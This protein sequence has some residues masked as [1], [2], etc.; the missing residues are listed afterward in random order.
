MAHHAILSAIRS[1]ERTEAYP[2]GS[3]K[4][5][6]FPRELDAAIEAG[7]SEVSKS[8]GEAAN[9]SKRLLDLLP[10]RHAADE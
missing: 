9:E 3:H 1:E 4:V 10:A 7:Y 6:Y 8:I 2:P 5:G